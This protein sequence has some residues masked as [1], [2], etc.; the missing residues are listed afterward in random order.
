MDRLVVIKQKREPYDIITLKRDGTKKFQ[1]SVG[2]TLDLYISLNHFENDPT[3][4]IGKDNYEV[5]QLF[6]ILY[7][8][9]MK[10]DIGFKSEELDL[11][12]LFDEEEM[13]EKRKK[14]L[15]FAYQ[16]GLIQD[17]SI[18]WK[19]DEIMD[20]VAPYF[21]IQKLKNAYKI[22][23]GIPEEIPNRSLEMCERFA[24]EDFNKHQYTCIRLRNNGSRY[25]NFS[26][27][28]MK[29]YN[30]LLELE[31]YH[32]IHIKEYM[33]NEEVKREKNLEKILIKK[34]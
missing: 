22:T 27:P 18:I 34:V 15:N 21:K 13:F 3:F 8:E 31:E 4:L 1:M 5:Y 32:Q 12:L 16:S 26:V 30:S 7:Q 25:R 14:N 19:D 2:G 23:F 29:L 10:G 17:G 6:G 33:I 11:F 28:F 9:V 20:D 24:L